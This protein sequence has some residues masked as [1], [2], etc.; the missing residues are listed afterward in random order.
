M[1]A[2]RMRSMTKIVSLTDL[3]FHH[4]L[5]ETSGAALV[6]FTAPH[7]GACRNLKRALV[8]FLHEYPPLPVF[9][10]DAVHNGGLVNALEVFHLPTL[11]LYVDGHYHRELHCEPLP[12]R[13]HHCI[14]I[15]LGLPAAEE[16]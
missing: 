14:G 13:I 7:C 8:K 16:P 15:A 1:G 10:V 6:F 11:F 12:I 3:N 5:A 2:C 4:L 9:E